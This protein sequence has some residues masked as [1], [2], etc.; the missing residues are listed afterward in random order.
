MELE[1]SSEYRVFGPGDR[2]AELM[3][4]VRW[5]PD[6]KDGLWLAQDGG[7]GIWQLK[8]LSELR[9]PVNEQVGRRGRWDQGSAV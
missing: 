4:L 3:Q 6:E 8:L 7:G 5:P 2:D 9:E 1:P